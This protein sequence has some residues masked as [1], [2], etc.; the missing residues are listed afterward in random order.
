MVV[1]TD[2][3]TDRHGATQRDRAVHCLE[4]GATADASEVGAQAA[5]AGVSG[6]M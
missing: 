5:L 6:N 1:V 2:P 3:L 4:I